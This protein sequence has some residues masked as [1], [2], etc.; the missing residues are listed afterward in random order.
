MKIASRWLVLL[1]TASTGARDLHKGSSIEG[2]VTLNATTF[3]SGVAI[4]VDGLGGSEHIESKSDGSGHYLFEEIR[5]G[6]YSMWA[7]AKGY[8]CILIP[9]V[10]VHYE[11][12]VRQDFNFIRGRAYGGCEATKK[13]SKPC[14]RENGSTAIANTPP[15]HGLGRDLNRGLPWSSLAHVCDRPHG[16]SP[17]GLQCTRRF[18]RQ[19]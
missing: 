4:G 11:E 9:R 3:L 15:P 16:T 10:A 6:A 14:P 7:D 1:L 18:G 5:P 19:V 17:I 13:R 8:G 12:R 2:F